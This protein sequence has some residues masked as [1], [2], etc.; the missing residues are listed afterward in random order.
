VVYFND[1]LR[2][3]HFLILRVCSVH[4]GTHYAIW[5]QKY[6]KKMDYANIRL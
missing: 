3:C 6:A 2:F 1:K 5:P 4:A